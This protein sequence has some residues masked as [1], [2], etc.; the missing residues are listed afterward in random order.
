MINTPALVGAGAGA[1]TMG[2]GTSNVDRATVKTLMSSVGIA[3]E[4]NEMLLDSVTGLAGSGP[5][6]VF[7]FIEA[8]ADGGVK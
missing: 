4:T 1:F 6:Y 8:L 5:A 3:Y 7:M 2:E